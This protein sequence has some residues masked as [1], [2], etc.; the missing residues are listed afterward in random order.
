MRM[1][2]TDRWS[3]GGTTGNQPSFLYEASY[4]AFSGLSKVKGYSSGILRWAQVW[5][6]DYNNPSQEILRT[7]WIL[8]FP[9]GTPITYADGDEEGEIR[10]VASGSYMTAN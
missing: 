5:E 1:N 2:G 3:N 7:G 4:N 8:C 6:L 9:D 10:V